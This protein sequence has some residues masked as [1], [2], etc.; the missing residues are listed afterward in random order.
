MNWCRLP[1]FNG[2]GLA[3]VEQWFLFV[4]GHRKR[5]QQDQQQ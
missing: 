5:P 2:I 1:R 3:E 4:F